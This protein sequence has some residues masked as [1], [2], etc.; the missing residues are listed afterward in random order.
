MAASAGY[1]S[2]VPTYEY[3]DL[4][5]LEH[6]PRRPRCDS[7]IN[8]MPECK[9]DLPDVSFTQIEGDM[10]KEE[11]VL[12]EF[13]RTGSDSET[14]A[15]SLE[16]GLQLPAL[17]VRTKKKR[18]SAPVAVTVAVAVELQIPMS[19]AKQVGTLSAE[20]RKRKIERY[21]EKRK[22]RSWTKKI[23]YDCRKR[24]A[25]NRL[26]VKGRFVTRL[27]AMSSLGVETVQKLLDSQTQSKGEVN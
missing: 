24:V 12:L 23:S 4:Q 10:D 2:E 22:R 11:A 25:D 19:P 14:Y 5:L 6:C 15:N 17:R 20:E 9:N 16:D 7:F 3:L 26:R 13:S 1:S 8:L 27:Q 18:P 21:L